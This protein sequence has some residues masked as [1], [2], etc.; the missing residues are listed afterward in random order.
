MG[1]IFLMAVGGLSI[2]IAAVF[3]RRR[4]VWGICLAASFP[5]TAAIV[6]AG[7]AIR[8]ALG[9]VMTA[10]FLFAAMPVLAVDPGARRWPWVA[11]AMGCQLAAVLFTPPDAPS[12]AGV[13]ALLSWALALVA[14]ILRYKHLRGKSV[15]WR[16]RSARDPRSAAKSVE[17]PTLDTV[18][19][20]DDASLFAAAGCASALRYD[21]DG[22]ETL[23]DAERS[24]CCLYLL[25][26]EVNN[27]GFGQWIW[28]VCP[29]AAAET[30][31]VLQAIGA[32]EMA[33]FVANTL[34]QFGDPTRFRSKDEWL[35]HYLSCPE[36]VHEHLE[37]LT[38][39]F[40]VL[41]DEF[42]KL[43]YAFARANWNSVRTARPVGS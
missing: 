4:W 12:M 2:L 24:L 30:P 21:E 25:E 43:A 1:E 20:W 15:D 22:F 18:G 36:D 7:L 33:S 8:L 19:E 40:L 37:T 5:L 14:L 11:A 16:L 32:T 23:N 35:N 17:F 26:T 28:N 38:P 3:L 13:A 41:E 9:A 39:A 42:L 10:H 31:L 6:P 34:L 29:R 27:G